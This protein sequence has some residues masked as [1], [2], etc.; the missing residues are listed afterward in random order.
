MTVGVPSKTLG[1]TG[2]YAQPVSICGAFEWP[3]PIIQAKRSRKLSPE[4]RE[5][6][7]MA[8]ERRRYRLWLRIASMKSLVS[9]VNNPLITSRILSI[10]VI[11]KA[12]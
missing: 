5:A 6:A 9:F 12:T 10:F 3:F 2:I 4:P 8:T 7:V 1:P 11:N